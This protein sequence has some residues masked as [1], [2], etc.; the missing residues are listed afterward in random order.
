MRWRIKA[1]CLA[2]RVAAAIAGGVMAAFS[3]A[4]CGAGQNED[5]AESYKTGLI[6]QITDSGVYVASEGIESATY[7]A[8]DG[9][10]WED[11]GGNAVTAEA[12]NVGQQVRYNYTAI[13]ESW[14]MQLVGCSR[15]V[16]TGH[17]EDVR[18]LVDEWNRTQ[19]TSDAGTGQLSLRLTSEAEKRKNEYP[20]FWGGK[21]LLVGGEQTA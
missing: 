17:E 12:L 4:G 3:I 8:F 16:V 10:S 13:L 5:A 15:V 20:T 18:A 11:S 1:K 6:F 2:S 21:E 9:V 7:I 14:P 19:Q